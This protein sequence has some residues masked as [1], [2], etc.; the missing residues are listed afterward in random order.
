MCV[1]V[2][3]SSISNSIDMTEVKTMER[4]LSHRATLLAL[5]EIA[6]QAVK[7]Q[8]ID[9]IACASVCRQTDGQTGRQEERQ[10]ERQ[11]DKQVDR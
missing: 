11:T 3:M 6:S 7:I 8:L 4:N 1:H 10:Q 9:A 5:L 2:C